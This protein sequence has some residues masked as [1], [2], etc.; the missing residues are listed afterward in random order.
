MWGGKINENKWF[1]I[2]IEE[3]FICCFYFGM[4]GW[5]NDG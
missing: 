3:W 4:L 5:F 1:I 2:E